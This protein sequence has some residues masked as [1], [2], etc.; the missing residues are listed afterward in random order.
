MLEALSREYEMISIE[1]VNQ[2]LNEIREDEKKMEKM[3]ELEKDALNQI[4][5][6]IMMAEEDDDDD[7]SDSDSD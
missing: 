2:Y 4:S 3:S 6:F 7:D 5:S 1:I